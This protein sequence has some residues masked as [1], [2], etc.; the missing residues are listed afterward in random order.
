MA[1]ANECPERIRSILDSL[2]IPLDLIAAR[3]LLGVSAPPGYSE[4]HSGGAVDVTTEGVPP[5]ELD[6]EDTPA[7]RWLSD[8]A[9]KFGFHLSFPRDNPCGY[10]YEPWHWCFRPA[11]ARRTP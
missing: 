10:A 1:V 5:L 9:H 11:D 8:H 7:F 4:H 6:F 2:Q 3:S